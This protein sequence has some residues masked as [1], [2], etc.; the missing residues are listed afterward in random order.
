MVLEELKK[1][2]PFWNKW[3]LEERLGGGSYGDVYRIKRIEYGTVYYAALKVISIPK[4]RAELNEVSLYCG[5]KDQTRT[6]FDN[7]RQSI[8]TEINMMERLKGKT[9][10][11]SYEDHDIIPKDHGKTPGYDIFIRMELLEDLGTA[12]AKDPIFFRNQ[13]EI[14]KIGMDICEALKLCHGQRIIHRDIKPGNIFRSQDGDYKL[15]DFGIARNLSNDQLTMSIK[16][17]Y[18][19][20]APEVYNREHYNTTADIYSLGMVLYHMLNGFRGPFLQSIEGV[21]SVDQKEDALIFRM[22]GEKLERPKNTS[23]RLAKVI[24][25]ACAYKP[26]ER[27]A[28]IGEFKKA[29]AS[30]ADEDIVC[31]DDKRVLDSQDDMLGEDRTVMINNMPQI[32]SGDIFS[33]NPVEKID[34]NRYEDDDAIPLIPIPDENYFVKSNQQVNAGSAKKDNSNNDGKYGREPEKDLPANKVSKNRKIIYIAGIAGS[35]II[36][37]FVIAIIFLNGNKEE[38][39]L[40]KTKTDQTIDIDS[41][42]RN[43]AKDPDQIINQTEPEIFTP[44][45]AESIVVYGKEDENRYPEGVYTG[46][47]FSE[48]QLMGDFRVSA[49][50]DTLVEGKLILDE[51]GT[52]KKSGTYKWKF[53]PEDKTKFETVTGTVYITAI[54]EDT[55]KGLK[56]VKAVEDKKALRDV[57][58]SDCELTDLSILK[59]AGNLTYLQLDSNNLTDISDLKDC[60]NLKFI[61]LN[62]NYNLSKVSVLLTLKHLN[63]V[64]LDSTNVSEEDLERINGICKNE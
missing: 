54:I 11:V 44:Q 38:A 4:D 36:A 27:Y 5:T 45:V 52:I 31:F 37:A 34:N 23:D 10:I 16:G 12:A 41:D 42:K 17:T 55:I 22:K 46:D 50:D 30:I 39:V 25:K 35:L 7:I 62:N 14:I 3:Y 40:D 8:I 15:G 58:L 51:K 59:G 9:N 29:L 18:D 19:Y 2:E 63:T 28:D 64:F 21:P 60:K 49:T 53:E 61:S 32:S 26:E 13:N 1:F 43:N 33:C 48:I 6:Y 24:L 20:M 56:A 57:D 47:K